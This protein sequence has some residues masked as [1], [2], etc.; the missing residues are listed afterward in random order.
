MATPIGMIEMTGLSGK[1]VDT[2]LLQKAWEAKAYVE[3]LFPLSPLGQMYKNDMLNTIGL[4]P[5]EEQA[6]SD[7]FVD[8]T[9][10][11]GVRSVTKAFLR[12][13]ADEAI[14]GNATKYI[15]NEKNLRMKYASFYANDYACP[16][17][18]AQGYGIDKRELDPYKVF[19][20]IVPLMWQWLAEYRDFAMHHACVE[21]I[22]SN[23]E[24]APLSQSAGLNEHIWFPVL[25]DVQQPAFVTTGSEYTE[26]VG[27]AATLAGASSATNQLTIPL[28]LDAAVY[29]Q[30]AYFAPANKKYYLLVSDKQALR[31][32]KGSVDDSFGDY[33]LN[34]GAEFDKVKRELPDAVGLIGD[35]VVLRNKRAPTI[36]KGGND[37]DWLITPGYMRMGRTDGR[38]TL[39]GANDFDVNIFCGAGMLAKMET[40]L[41]HIEE[42]YDDY[43]RYVGHILVGACSYM[44]CR[45][46]IDTATDADKRQQ[47]GCGLIL[48]SRM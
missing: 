23:L 1:G 5:E 37:S 33:L 29:Y 34:T 41:P 8:I 30:N 46:D 12:S 24:G 3:S 10:D 39:T 38:S 40:E 42:Q 32:S 27:D 18:A 4:G 45:Y 25:T 16:P 48:T 6:P 22:S 31:L 19:D 9:S 2:G 7:I 43:K 44:T 17:I 15:G 35:V 11:A 20:K 14:E 36:R 21:N 26:A 28:I 47:E 13:L